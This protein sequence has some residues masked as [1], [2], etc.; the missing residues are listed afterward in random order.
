MRL[1]FPRFRQRGLCRCDL[2]RCDRRRSAFTMVELLVVV[3]L[4]SI[5]GGLVANAMFGAMESARVSRTRAQITRL[6]TLVRELYADYLYRRVPIQIDYSGNASVSPPPLPPR[7]AAEIRLDAIREMMRMELP[8]RI[9]DVKDRPARP[10]SQP[11][12][13]RNYSVGNHQ[14]EVYWGQPPSL[15]RAYNRAYLNSQIGQ[16]SIEHQGAECLYLI[17]AMATDRNRKALEFFRDSEI[18]DVD[19]DGMREILD[20]WGTPIRF[21]RWPAGFES[22]IQNRDPNEFPDPFDPMG[23]YPENYALYP[24][25]MSAGP[26][27]QWDINF[28]SVGDGG[29]QVRYARTTPPNDPYYVFTFENGSPAQF[30]MPYQ[31]GDEDHYDNLHNHAFRTRSR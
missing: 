6:D 21:L 8:D 1:E 29:A 20:A 10:G 4:L 23:I 26:D 16:W 5:L 31:D 19:G 28:T 13:R 12:H 18:G 17:I 27:R 25:I 22:E 11:Q 7:V 9:T 2:H 3:L 24:L 30:G 15:W 14:W